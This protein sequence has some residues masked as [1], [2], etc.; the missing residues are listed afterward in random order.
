MESATFTSG[1]RILL[2]YSP[3]C[4]AA[5][6][7]AEQSVGWASHSR[8]ADVQHVGVNHRRRHVRV[9]EQLLHRADVLPVFQQ[10]R[11]ERVPQGVGGGVLGDPGRSHRRHNAPVYRTR[12]GVVPFEEF[13]LSVQLGLNR[14]GDHGTSVIAW[15]RRCQNLYRISDRGLRNKE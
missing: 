6:H 1:R 2:P 9:A 11:G 5:D 7:P 3:L 13:W 14:S 8:H 4:A 10:V 15:R 12:V